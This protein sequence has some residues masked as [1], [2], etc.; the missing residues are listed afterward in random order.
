[1]GNF[2]ETNTTDTAVIPQGT[3]INGNISMTG[4]LEMYGEVNGNIDSDDR[5]DICGN[6]T[7]NIKANDLYTKDSLIVGQVDCAQ[8]AVVYENTVILGG[9]NAENLV[10]DGAVQGR[11]D[12]RDGITVGDRAIVD[13]DIRAKTIQVNNGAIL[14]GHCST[15]Y[16]A[17]NIKEIFPA[18]AEP[19]TKEQTIK[20]EAI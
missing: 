8:E 13:S 6:V 5:V 19:E 1:M 12:I 2:G 16:A 10:V 17:V 3:V 20:D 7:G 11:L 15:C 9:I 18:K 4:R 14:N